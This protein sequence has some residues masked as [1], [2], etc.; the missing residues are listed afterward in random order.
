MTTPPLS[1]SVPDPNDPACLIGH[2]TVL[3][4]LVR[5]NRSGVLARRLKEASTPDP[6][7]W[8]GDTP[9]HVA[10]R[11]GLDGCVRVLLKAGAD[12]SLLGRSK[13][14]AL[15]TSVAVMES[16]QEEY[17]HADG[18]TVCK[19][20]SEFDRGS[21][22]WVTW[23]LLLQ[24]GGSSANEVLDFA[25]RCNHEAAACWALEHGADPNAASADGETPLQV[26]G[27]RLGGEP[28]AETR[29]PYGSVATLASFLVAAGADP[30]LPS[31]ARG[32]SFRQDCGDA[33]WDAIAA[34]AL[35]WRPRL[36]PASDPSPPKT[37]RSRS[38][39]S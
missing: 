2:T 27:L 1:S 19:I 4:D 21:G 23:T 38:R 34:D 5:T 14:T 29:A 36:P 17:T 35:T 20:P 9:L 22:F 11:K 13:T 3:H 37:R 16:R 7:D 12:P 39:A 24:A 31:A 33:W 30:D 6:R 25:V 18:H 28:T 15:M 8:P 32:T 26:L 10:A